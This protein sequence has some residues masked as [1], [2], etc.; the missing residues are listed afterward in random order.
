MIPTAVDIIR[1]TKSPWVGDGTFGQL[2]CKLL[3]FSQASSIAC[4]IISLTVLAFE[5]FFVVV[6]PLWNVVTS[7][8][9]SWSIAVIWLAVLA[10]SWPFLYAGKVRLFDGIPYCTEYWAPAFDP[11]RAPAIYTIESFVFLYAFPLLVI[12]VLYSVIAVKVWSRRTPGNV[13][14]VSRRVLQKNKKNVLKMSITVVLTFAIYW[15]LIHLNLLFMDFSDVFEPCGIPSWLQITGFLLGHASS[16]M[17][18]CIY[19]IFSQEY[20]QRFK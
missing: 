9:T 15:F 5:R 19:P 17:N 2:S 7:R 11:K 20:R 8:G 14:A 16:A 10:L 18:C 3:I 6:F 1:G 13:N 12:A 4:S